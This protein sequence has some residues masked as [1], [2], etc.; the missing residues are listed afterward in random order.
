MFRTKLPPS[1]Q[2]RPKKCACCVFFSLQSCYHS[3]SLRAIYVWG[4]IVPSLSIGH[5]EEIETKK[6]KPNPM[7][8]E[9]IAALAIF[10]Q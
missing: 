3:L 2:N 7:N 1:R 10:V 4:F 6:N 9:D 8:T 5:P